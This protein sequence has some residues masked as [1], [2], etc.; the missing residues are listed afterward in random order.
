MNKTKLAQERLIIIPP[1]PVRFTLSEWELNNR[2]NTRYTLDQQQLA[3]RIL[4]ESERLCDKSRESAER[5]KLET[6]HKI[7]ERISEIQFRKNETEINRK[8]IEMEVEA[9]MTY[10]ERIMDALAYIK[11]EALRICKTCLMLRDGRLGI[12]LVQDN[13]DR[14]MMKEIDI[15]EGA[16]IMLQ[17]VLEQT[18]EQVR[19]LRSTLYFMDRELD[20]KSNVLKVDKQ[21][22]LLTEN[23]LNLSIYHGHTPLANS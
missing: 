8:D 9:L 23:C 18:H 21:L 17:R 12:D 15:I 22:V 1:Q 4:V 20:S 6:N 11:S 16:Q 14:E 13:C 5:N 2:T 7:D 3:Q 19:R 10:K